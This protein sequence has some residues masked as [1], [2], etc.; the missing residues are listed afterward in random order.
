[1]IIIITS[2]ASSVLSLLTVRAGEL[3]EPLA[4]TSSKASRD[5]EKDRAVGA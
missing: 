3:H 5:S 2:F 1:M 4:R